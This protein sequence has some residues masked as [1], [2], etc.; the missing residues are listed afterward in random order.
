MFMTKSWK[1]YPSNSKPNPPHY[2]LELHVYLQYGILIY[3]TI[4]LE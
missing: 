3:Y 1:I 2:D 4:N